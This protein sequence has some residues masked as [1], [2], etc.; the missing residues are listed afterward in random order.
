MDYSKTFCPWWEIV[1]AI[2]F[3][4]D[5]VTPIM[6]IMASMCLGVAS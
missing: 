2:V 4:K 5:R 6:H 1:M 3:D